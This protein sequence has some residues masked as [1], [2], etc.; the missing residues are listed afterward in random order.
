MSTILTIQDVHKGPMKVDSA[1]GGIL[2]VDIDGTVADIE[3]RRKYVQGGS[4]NWGAFNARMHLDS[5]KP[6]I[7]A[8]VQKLY[9]AGW[10]VVMCTGRGDDNKVVTVNWLADNNVPYHHIFMRR[11]YILDDAGEVVL[12]RKGKKQPDSRRDD[13]IKEEILDKAIENGLEPTLI[14]DDRNQVV[15]M[16]RRRGYCCVQVAEGDF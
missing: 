4:H 10:T 16:W 9:A 12:S 8:H 5:P 1:A 11:Q 14:L 15:D 2:F 6:D 3:H 7:I 13:I